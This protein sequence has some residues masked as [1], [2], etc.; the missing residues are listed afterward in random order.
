MSFKR[1]SSSNSNMSVNQEYATRAGT[2]GINR[3]V[4]RS[5]DKS[6]NRSSSSCGN[7]SSNN[8]SNRTE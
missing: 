1:N 6:R 2:G 4:N 8:C 5:S 3:S 7:R